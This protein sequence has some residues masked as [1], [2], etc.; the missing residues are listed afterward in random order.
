MLY[1]DVMVLWYQHLPT[2]MVSIVRVWNGLV[3]TTERGMVSLPRHPIMNMVFRYSIY[4]KEE[5]RI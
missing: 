1:T 5:K 3:V 2:G 4:R